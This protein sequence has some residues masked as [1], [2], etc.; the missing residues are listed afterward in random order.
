MKILFVAAT[1]EEIAPIRNITSSHS[2]DYLITGPGMVATTYELTKKLSEKKY[3]LAI[4]I[5]LAGSFDPTIEIGETV[6]VSEDIFSELGAED[7]D[8]FLDIEKIGLKSPFIFYPTA[9]VSDLKIRKVKS[10]TVNSVHGNNSSIEKIQARLN[11]QTETMEGAAFFFV[12][13]KEKTP[14]FQIRTISNFVERRNKLSWNIPLA[15]ENLSKTVN[16]ILKK[17]VFVQPVDSKSA[18]NHADK[19]TAYNE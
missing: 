9:D 18:T 6:Y 13:K 17:D 7:G 19:N 14:A 3:D 16:Q 12:C 4:N 10:I 11:P 15:L 8:N 2:L 5:G 1:E